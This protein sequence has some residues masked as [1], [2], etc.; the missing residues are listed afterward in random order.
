MTTPLAVTFVTPLP[1]LRCVVEFVS[2]SSAPDSYTVTATVGT[3]PSQVTY[4]G[5]GSA[6]PITIGSVDYGSIMS[7]TVSATTG[8]TVVTGPA[9]SYTLTGVLT[10]YAAILRQRLAEI[11]AAASISGMRLIGDGYGRPRLV[12]QHEAFTTNNVMCEVGI[13]RLRQAQLDGARSVATYEIQ[14]RLFEF[15][16]DEDTA[17]DRLWR[18]FELVRKAVD[19]TYELGL[20]GVLSRSWSWSNVEA[21]PDLDKQYVALE[22]LLVVP[23][24]TYGDQVPYA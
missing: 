5:T 4:T 10:S 22:A 3:G 24:Q 8:Q 15:S 1:T 7:I 18:I 23:L 14:I 17:C 21:V 6:S 11:L 9:Y 20:Y 12:G 16:S 19:V 2:A 13:P